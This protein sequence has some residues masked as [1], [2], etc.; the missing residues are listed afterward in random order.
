MHGYV[1]LNIFYFFRF[2]DC[3]RTSKAA[4][5]G[6]NFPALCAEQFN[7]FFEMITHTVNSTMMS[8]LKS[9]GLFSNLHGNNIAM[10]GTNCELH[11]AATGLKIICSKTL[12]FSLY[13]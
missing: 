13:N 10:F 3:R 4:L 8:L 11:D 7:L 5:L 1:S 6:S 9:V 12:H 2:A